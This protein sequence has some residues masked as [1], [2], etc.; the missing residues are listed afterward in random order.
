[1]S[2]YWP[3][4]A[5]AAFFTATPNWARRGGGLVLS[6]IGETTMIRALGNALCRSVK[7]AV[8]AGVIWASSRWASLRPPLMTTIDGS[9][10]TTA[11]IW[12]AYPGQVGRPHFCATVAFAGLA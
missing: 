1:M 6:Q 9:A 2:Q 7:N 3:P 8:T 11:A 5:T 4:T 10:L 12:S